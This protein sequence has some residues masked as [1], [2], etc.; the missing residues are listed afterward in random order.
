LQD[1]LRAKEKNLRDLIEG[2]TNEK[3]QAIK[4]KDTLKIE[5]EEL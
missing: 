4:S 3:D 1:E 2:I 5:N